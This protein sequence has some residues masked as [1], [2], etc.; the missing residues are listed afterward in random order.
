MLSLWFKF[1]NHLSFAAFWNI[2]DEYATCWLEIKLTC[3]EGEYE[4]KISS[5][6]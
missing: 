5:Q 3:E 1:D 6:M 2:I 4:Y